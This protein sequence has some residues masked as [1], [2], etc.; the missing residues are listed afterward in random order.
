MQRQLIAGS[1]V[2]VRIDGPPHPV[3]VKLIAGSAALEVHRH[4]HFGPHGQR[5][6]LERL[7]LPVENRT[8]AD[9]VAE[10]RRTIH[11]AASHHRV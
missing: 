11:A 2:G 4:R 7:G 6:P 1:G 5:A 10:T 9:V 8:A 3:I